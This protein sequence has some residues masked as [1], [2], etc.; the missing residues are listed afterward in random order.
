M[1]SGT[2]QLTKIPKSGSGT[3]HQIRHD[4]S[5]DFHIEGCA[6]PNDWNL[7][8]DLQRNISILRRIGIVD[9]ENEVEVETS[10][11]SC[12]YVQACG[13]QVVK[14][15][16]P[17]L[18]HTGSSLTFRSIS[19]EESREHVERTVID[20]S[21]DSDPETLSISVRSDLEGDSVDPVLSA[22]RLFSDEDLNALEKKNSAVESDIQVGALLIQRKVCFALQTADPLVSL[23]PEP[24]FAPIMSSSSAAR[25]LILCRRWSH[26]QIP[27]PPRA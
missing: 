23:G 25:H 26:C 11:D 24:R 3:I 1:R 2:D 12:L 13:I 6:E 20:G 5:V 15:S 4:G 18:L 27:K 16:D 14:S 7:R 21:E 10:L 19:S 9:S 17:L 8:F 22:L